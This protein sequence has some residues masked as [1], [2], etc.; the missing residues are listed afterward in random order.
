MKHVNYNTLIHHNNTTTLLVTARMR[1]RRAMQRR[2]VPCRA[3]PRR[4]ASHC[5]ALCVSVYSCLYRS[6]C[7][8]LCVG[9]CTYIM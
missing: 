8:H 3:V 1:V 4:A 5:V 2:A 6:P 7:L 9:I